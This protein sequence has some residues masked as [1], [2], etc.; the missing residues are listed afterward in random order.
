[1]PI[2]TSLLKINLCACLSVREGEG[3]TPTAAMTN[4]LSYVPTESWN[5]HILLY[6]PGDVNCGSSRTRNDPSL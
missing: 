6:S 5:M 4:V 3:L 1:M 2:S